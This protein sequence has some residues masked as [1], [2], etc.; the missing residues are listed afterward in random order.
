MKKIFC[1]PPAQCR[2]LLQSVGGSLWHI[3][4]C[5]QSLGLHYGEAGLESTPAAALALQVITTAIVTGPR[6]PLAAAKLKFDPAWS[7]VRR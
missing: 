4:N 6:L 5:V 1:R 7:P 2:G 3:H